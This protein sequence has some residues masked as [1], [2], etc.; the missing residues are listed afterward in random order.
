MLFD[1]WSLV[2]FYAVKDDAQF[3]NVLQPNLGRDPRVG[4]Q[5]KKSCLGL[6]ISYKIRRYY[7]GVSFEFIAQ[8]ELIKKKPVQVEGHLSWFDPFR[9]RAAH[10]KGELVGW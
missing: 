6:R 1:S 3:S 9:A 4:L 5:A 10:G 2:K 8:I 7:D